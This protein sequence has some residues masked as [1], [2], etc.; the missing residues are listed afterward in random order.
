MYCYSENIVLFYFLPCPV[1]I[2]TDPRSCNNPGRWHSMT[3][4][5]G[6]IGLFFVYPGPRID[7]SKR[8]QS[9]ACE[10]VN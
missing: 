9:F 7:V 4:M 2:L 1:N 3:C 6:V 8:A 10:N 5:Y